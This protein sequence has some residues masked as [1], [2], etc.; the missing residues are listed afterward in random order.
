MK[1]TAEA[2]RAFARLRDAAATRIG[3]LP[4]RARLTLPFAVLMVVLFGGIALVLYYTFAA[5]L[6]TSLETALVS[7]AGDVR[8]ELS[9]QGAT[10]DGLPL[11]STSGDYAQI[12]S[13][14]GRVLNYYGPR[15]SLLSTAQRVEA[16]RGQL[17]VSS[18]G[19]RLLAEPLRGD[20]L[21]VGVSLAQR[22][23]A[24][25]TLGDLL[26]VGGPIALLLVCAAG[27]ILAERVL[28]PVERMR[29]RAEVISGRRPGV[30]LP[31]PDTRDELQRLGETLNEMLARLDAALGR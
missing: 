17:F 8:N 13:A 30:R 18:Q 19:Q 3:R 25:N 10:I 11:Y 29:Q 27:Y 7:R 1:A 4:V 9:L 5:G 28:A 24:L 2:R 22:N 15:K 16:Q 26:F 6:D 12:L 20:V 21:V 23:G 14:D 31:V